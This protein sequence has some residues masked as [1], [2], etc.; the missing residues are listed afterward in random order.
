MAVAGHLSREGKLVH[1][2]WLDR[3]ASRIQQM[4]DTIRYA[5]YGYHGIFDVEKIGDAELKALYEFDLSLLDA[6][7]RIL[8]QIPD[9]GDLPAPEALEKALSTLE[10]SIELWEKTF[11]RRGE[12][13]T[14][15]A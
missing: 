8:K 11:R 15:S 4:A 2:S 5:R 1:L 10:E 12:L 13:L 9:S 3:V 14:S 7:D 6:V